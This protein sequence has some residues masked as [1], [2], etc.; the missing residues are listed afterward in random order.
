MNNYTVILVALL[1]GDLK[2]LERAAEYVFGSV[3][4]APRQ[5]MREDNSYLFHGHLPYA[6]GYGSGLTQTR[7]RIYFCVRWNTLVSQTRSP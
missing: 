7:H 3:R 5:G 4:Y 2:R 1:D 6:G